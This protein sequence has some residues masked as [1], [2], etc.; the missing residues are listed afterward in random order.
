MISF[1]VSAIIFIPS[2][3]L[4]LAGVKAAGGETAVPDKK[5]DMF[6]GIYLKIRHPQ[7]LGE[8][9]IWFSFA[10]VLNSPFLLLFS[11]IWILI[12]YIWIIFEERDLE[13]RYGKNYSNYKQITGIFPKKPHETET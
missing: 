11:I 6:N 4:I 3:I 1:V 9:P 13:I 5:G 10:L 8:V 2:L 12:Y 7:Y